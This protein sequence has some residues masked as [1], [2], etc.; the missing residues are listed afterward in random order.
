MSMKLFGT[1]TSPY[2]RKVRVVALEKHIEFEFVTEGVAGET[3]VVNQHNPLGKIPALALD[4]GFNL[5]DSPVIVE[6]LDD[7]SP[8]SHLIPDG[9]R[10]RALVK[11]WEALADGLLDAG[12]L[13]FL[14]G[15]RPENER[16]PAWVEKQMGKIERSLAFMSQELGKKNYCMGDAL[17]LADIAVGCALFWIGFRFPELD[18]R[19]RYPN[20]HA[21]A[22][23]L[24][25][26]KSFQET[27]PKVV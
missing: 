3:A 26:R 23:K 12:V 8:V 14:E 22:E 13:V 9:G 4:D 5:F 1:H 7:I 2:V 24:A 18:W 25:Q 15:R 27:I 19:N 21:L 10:E 6:Y 11:R 17:T 20:L 16:S